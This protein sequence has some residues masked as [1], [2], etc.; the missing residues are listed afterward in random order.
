MHSKTGDTIYLSEKGE[1]EIKR[2]F[3]A[4]NDAHREAHQT[5]SNHINID[6]QPIPVEQKSSNNKNKA[7]VHQFTSYYNK[8]D[9]VTSRLK[10]KSY[11]IYSEKPHQ[12]VSPSNADK[13]SC[14]EQAYIQFQ[15]DA[16]HITKNDMHHIKSRHIKLKNKKTETKNLIK[17][18]QT[19]INELSI[20]L[21]KKDKQ[22][23]D[24]SR[25][26]ENTQ[27]LQ[28]QL[29]ISALETKSQT[30]FSD[31]NENKTDE[32]KSFFNKLFFHKK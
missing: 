7:D 29:Q 12:T 25:L 18:M 3:V 5:A 10:N 21:Q 14:V 15:N 32:K 2:H 30:N 1:A 13:S 17:L 22:I 8:D 27:K 23:D 26:L 20:Q 28:L 31:K 4:K 19:T 16:H 11:H 24:L 6:M 9:A